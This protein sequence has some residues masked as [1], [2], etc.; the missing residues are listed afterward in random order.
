MLQ[1]YSLNV[2]VA[3]DGI[4]PFNNVTVDKGCAEK[5]SGVGTIELNKAGVYKVHVDGVASVSTSI[6]LMRNGTPLSQAQ[7][8][9]T[10][11]GFGTFVQV[12]KNNC[13]CD[14]GSSPVTIQ[15]KNSTEATFIN[16]NIV[17]EKIA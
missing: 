7:S 17:V 12:D 1:A 13:A 5:L 2:D 3:A 14:C 8:T 6:Q 9:G 16:V 11:V 15:L 10:V 4:V